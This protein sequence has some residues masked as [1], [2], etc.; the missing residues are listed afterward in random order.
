[1]T[2]ARFG[3]ML[4]KRGIAS[5]K[6]PGGVEAIALAVCEYL[7]KALG[8]PSS[9]SKIPLERSVIPAIEDIFR[10]GAE[11]IRLAPGVDPGTFA[12]AVAWAIFGAASRWAQ[13][14]NRIP[15]EEMAEI[16]ESL[17]KPL[18]W[19]GASAQSRPECA[20]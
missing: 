2:A 1:M 5:P 17:V 15:A 7:A 13:T 4:E 20:S 12:T 6:C 9:L 3:D 16:I 14:P 8:C 11:E 19:S 10:V 18:V